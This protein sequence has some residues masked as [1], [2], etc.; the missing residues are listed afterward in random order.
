MDYACNFEKA[1][2]VVNIEL[3]TVG[4]DSKR[5]VQSAKAIIKEAPLQGRQKMTVDDEIE[6]EWPI[7]CTQPQLTEGRIYYVIGKD[8]TAFNDAGGTSLKYELTG[9]A[10]VIDPAYKPLLQIVMNSFVKDL[11]TNTGC[12]N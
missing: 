1:N 11:K 2:Y 6:F 12:N 10:L 4:Y 5:E 7:G 8:G 9:T 3:E